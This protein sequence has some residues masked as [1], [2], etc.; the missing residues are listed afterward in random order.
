M[1]EPYCPEPPQFEEQVNT[2]SP[3]T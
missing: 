1:E 3:D 2:V